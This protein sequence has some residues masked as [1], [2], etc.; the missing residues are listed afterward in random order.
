[1][2]AH[3]LS[4]LAAWTN[5][6]TRNYLTDLMKQKGELLETADERKSGVSLTELARSRQTSV[7]QRL[8]AVHNLERAVVVIER[9]YP[10]GS[11]L[12]GLLLKSPY[13]TSRELAR[14]LDTTEANV[15]QM[16][17]RIRKLLRPLRRRSPF[18]HRLLASKRL[19]S[20]SL[21]SN[22]RSPQDRPVSLR[23]PRRWATTQD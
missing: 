19:R 9:H 4:R 5:V 17:F 21:R 3:P 8:D 22:R 1:M 16:R 7:E 11:P 6:T 10:T 15:D 13:A 23:T 18:R 20:S 2:V 14:A 12:L